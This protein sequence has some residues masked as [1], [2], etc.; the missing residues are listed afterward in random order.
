MNSIFELLGTIAINNKGAN[1]GIDE[2]TNKAKGMQTK[3][4]QAFN[5]I[6]KD[7]IACGKAVAKGL[8]VVG[9]AGAA[10]TGALLKTSVSS[11]K[12]FEQLEG[13]VKKLFGNSWGAVAENAKKA[14][15]TAGLSANQY[16]EQA[17]SFSASL[18]K[19]LGGDTAAA[20][21][22][23]D[24]AITDM[25]DNAN[26]FGTDI[27]MIQNAYQGFA[28][29]NY[30]MLDNLKLGYG[31]TKEE[32]ARLI[33]ESGVM[34]KTFK[35]TA[36]NVDDVSFAKIIEAI[37]VVQGNM[38]IAGATANEASTTIEGSFNMWKASWKNLMTGLGDDENIDPL[39][40]AFFDAGNTVL[41]NLNRVLPK[42]GKNLKAAMV[43]AGENIRKAWV[44]NIWP[45]IQKFTT[46]H[47]GIELPEWTV[48]ES[49]LTSW[50]E[51]T[52]KPAVDN[53]KSFFTDIATWISENQ[54][55]VTG[56]LF[57]T[58]GA[59]LMINAPL[60]L[61]YAALF[62]VAANWETIKT[63]VTNALDA[64]NN[65]FTVTIPDAWKN[66]VKDIKQWWNENVKTPIDNAI[67]AVREFLG[68]EADKTI[69]VTTHYTTSGDEF[70]GGVGPRF[71]N[72]E[73]PA[74][75]AASGLRYVPY[76]NFPVRLHMGETVLP[77]NEAEEYRRGGN[78]DN[79][80]LINAINALSDRVTAVMQQVAANTG[81]RQQLALN[82]GV[83][84]GELIPE[85]DA[86]L[87]QRTARKERRG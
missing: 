9:A 12:E 70:G 85:I 54:Q 39:V 13:G 33:N 65:F 40:D 10:V 28:K 22:V 76:D 84:A 51:G 55:M 66:M 14:Y 7:A 86:K 62:L 78:A 5:K 56:F 75:G 53:V 80:G 15:K 79:S 72:E 83:I 27:S 61:L 41:K 59:L 2:T 38:D 47:F 36:K 1:K 17:T 19:G 23:A 44:Q 63:A 74:N 18:I 57:A 77:R 52:G 37:H 81:A 8:A 32:M 69:T 67:M 16:M 30:T 64:V 4:T 49:S 82:N 71:G 21:K 48:I 58:A 60:T 25:A 11:Y 3:M 6:S 45:N 35:A 24:T 42:I 50:W 26:T 46:I 68:M 31:G 43:S 34:G 29:Q 73:T 20:A 87:G